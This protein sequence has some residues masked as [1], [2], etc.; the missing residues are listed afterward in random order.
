MSLRGIRKRA[1]RK[2]HRKRVKE[3]QAKGLESRAVR[4]KLR[5]A[6]SG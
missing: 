4:K 5:Q 2:A 6:R 1:A 3:Q